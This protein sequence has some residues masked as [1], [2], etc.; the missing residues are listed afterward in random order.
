MIGDPNGGASFSVTLDST[1]NSDS[2]VALGYMQADVVV[3]YLNVVR[4][5]L[6]NLEGGGSVTV[7]VSNSA[8]S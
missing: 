2:Q 6:I 3:K 5:F 4:Y 1:N 7:S 8:S